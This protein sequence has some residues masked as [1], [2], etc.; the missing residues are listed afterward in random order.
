[1]PMHITVLG[2]GTSH[3]VPMIGCH[4]PVCSSSDPRNRRLRSSAAVRLGDHTLLIDTTPDLRLQAITYGLDRVDAVAYT[5]SHAD[6]VMG[7]DELRRYSELTR[8]ATPVY[9]APSALADLHRIFR[10]VLTDA[11]FD[12]FGI[13]VVD[14]RPLVGP[15]DL[16]G[17]R[18]TPVPVRHGIHLAT[19]LRIDGPG[20]SM[21]WCPDCCGFP[22]GSREMLGGLDVLFLDGLRHRPHPTHFTVAE[23]V[24]AIRGL[25]PRR[26]F[27]IHMTH[28]LDHATTEA[29][30]PALPEVPGGIRLAYDGMTVEVGR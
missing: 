2:S 16:W 19:C 1:M 5:H 18:L 30:L 14:W 3:G 28:D 27:L 23:S 26:A 29:A 22:D 17:Y 13:P 8:R 6:H 12:M 21:A 10:Y 20:G 11:S 15:V 4:C 24:E 9:A 25:A 7:L